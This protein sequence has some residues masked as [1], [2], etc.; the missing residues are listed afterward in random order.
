MEIPPTIKETILEDV[1]FQVGRTGVITPVG[2]VNP[3][4]IDGAKVSRVTLHNE[5]E[6][7]KKNLRLG[8]RV[9]IIRS[10]DVIP[11]ILK[12]LVDKRDGSE[13]VIEFAQNCPVCQNPL[14]RDEGGAG[15]IIRCSNSYC[16][17]KVVNS[18]RHFVSKDAMDIDG[19][20]NEFVEELLEKNIIKNV[21]DLYHITGKD[22]DKFDRMGEKLK[23]NLLGS[24]EKSKDITLGRFIYALGIKGVGSKTATVLAQK[25]NDQDGFR[26]M[27]KLISATKEDLLNIEDIG[28]TVAE[29]IVSYFNDD[30]NKKIIQDLLTSDVNPKVERVTSEGPLKGKKLLFTGTLTLSRRIAKEQAQK[31]GAEIVSNISKHTDI[32]VIGENA[33]SKLKKAK[34]LKVE[35][36][37]EVDFRKIISGV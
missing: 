23:A 19:L 31:A 20:G 21:S 17:A 8:D 1:S 6:I 22:L 9:H 11:K 30:E 14:K 33:G 26:S 12:A 25:F 16:P 3:V 4:L 5:R 10:G 13:R 24:I 34:E 37:N 2:H 28:E 18:I 29:C 7:I 36:M 32:L 27:K 35:I 15:V